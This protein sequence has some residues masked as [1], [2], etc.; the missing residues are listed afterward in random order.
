MSGGAGAATGRREI[1][2]RYGRKDMQSIKN[3][4]QGYRKCTLRKHFCHS[5]YCKKFTSQT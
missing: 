4:M 2:E 1:Q 5:I 3:D